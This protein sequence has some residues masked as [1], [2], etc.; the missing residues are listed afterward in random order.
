MLKVSSSAIESCWNK[1]LGK[2]KQEEPV[3]DETITFAEEK[4]P[5]KLKQVS[6]RN[7]FGPKS[8]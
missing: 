7:Y 1:S 8:A 2:E 6:I 4:A 5:V 3:E